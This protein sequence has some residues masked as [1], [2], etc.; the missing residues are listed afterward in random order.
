MTFSC[1][2]IRDRFDDYAADALTREE[3][4]G[5]REHLASCE[6][7][8]SE[9]VVADPLFL[10]A[11]TGAES[12]SVNASDVSRVLEGVRAG[13]ALKQA[14]RKI[15]PPASRRR[16]SV[17]GAAAAALLLTLLAPGASSRRE[18]PAAEPAARQAAE[19]GFSPAAAPVEA[20]P[21]QPG[22]T[23]RFP[24]DA[25]IYDFNQGAGQPR[26]VWIVD[27]SIDI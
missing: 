23:R 14:E 12:A 26:V 10:F 22:G 19:T 5:L 17:A 15:E 4:A 9:A 8:R 11:R 6:E 16:W 27:R 24:A 25:T 18:T 1:G 20:V 7:C 13:I 2:Q 21:V 3:R